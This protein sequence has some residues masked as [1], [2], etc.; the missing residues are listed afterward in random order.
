[1]VDLQNCPFCNGQAVYN[2]TITVAPKVD[3]CCKTCHATISTTVSSNM[4]LEK[5]FNAYQ[6]AKNKVIDLWNKRVQ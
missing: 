3:I 4:D 5:Y 2:A 1:M 6:E